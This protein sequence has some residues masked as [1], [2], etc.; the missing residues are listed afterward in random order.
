[1]RSKP[2]LAIKIVKPK[3]PRFPVY[4]EEDPFYQEGYQKGLEI[5]KTQKGFG[6]VSRLLQNTNFKNEKIAFLINVELS[7]IEEV[8]AKIN[9]Q[10]NQIKAINDE[11]D[12][13][14]FDNRD[15]INV[16]NLLLQTDF[17][18]EK[19]SAI[20]NVDLTFVARVK[21]L[22]AKTER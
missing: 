6:I 12:L 21:K 1:M 17:S 13:A 16:R 11:N 4:Q 19:I 8:R 9:I 7:F 20:A 10:N 14:F 5:A 15:F 18:D 22:L 2:K 3:T